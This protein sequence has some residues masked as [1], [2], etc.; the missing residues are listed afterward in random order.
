LLPVT[1]HRGVKCKVSG[2]VFFVLCVSVVHWSVNLAQT[3][4]RVSI[5]Q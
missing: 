1:C 2:A 5:V 4:F 3:A